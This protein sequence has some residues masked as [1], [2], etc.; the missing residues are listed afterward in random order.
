[1]LVLFVLLVLLYVYADQI[2][3]TVPALAGILANYVAGVDHLR[4]LLDGQI[5]A[6]LS[7]LDMVATES[8]N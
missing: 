5:T 2:A 7:W 8:V 4:L 1:M 6:L 3:A